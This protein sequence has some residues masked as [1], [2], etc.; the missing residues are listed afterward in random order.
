VAAVKRFMWVQSPTGRLHIKYGNTSEG[1]AKCG[2]FMKKG[3]KIVSPS[4]MASRPVACR[5]CQP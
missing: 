5:R 4:R 3:W 1:P 2:T